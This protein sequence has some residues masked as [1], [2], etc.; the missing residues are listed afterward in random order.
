M[1]HRARKYFEKQKEFKAW[2]RDWINLAMDNPLYHFV[3]G[4]ACI[5]SSILPRTVNLE[6]SPEFTDRIET[7]FKN[8][9]M[10]VKDAKPPAFIADYRHLSHIDEM[11]MLQLP[12]IHIKNW[13]EGIRADVLSIGGNPEPF[14]TPLQRIQFFLEIDASDIQDEAILALLDKQCDLA[15][16]Y[17]LEKQLEK[18]LGHGEEE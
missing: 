15:M 3:P 2:K 4:R 5:V 18:D 6:L 17:Q 11:A 16:W 9:T 1:T 8:F 10:I 13:R 14:F 12:P 7:A